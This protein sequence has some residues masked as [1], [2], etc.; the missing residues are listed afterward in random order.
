LCYLGKEYA[1]EIPDYA[2]LAQQ[3]VDGK[4]IGWF[5]GKSEFGPRALGNRSILADPRNHHNRELINH[6]I[7]SREWFRPFAPVVLEED[8]QDWFDFP[9]PSPFML[10]T[11]QV[12][13]S[14]KIPAVTHIDGSARFQTINEET[15]SQYYNLIKQ[16]KNITGVPV[17]LNTSLNGNGEPILETEDEAIQ[18]FEKSN[19]DMMIVNVKIINN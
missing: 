9:I 12:K 13:Q 6:I 5:Q 2:Y 11:A 17:L 7:K 1:I 19:L 14:E 3:I 4:I 18:F 15:N 16:F 8:Y 10:Y